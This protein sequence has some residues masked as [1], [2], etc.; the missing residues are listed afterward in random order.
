MY[1]KILV[2]IY[3]FIILYLNKRVAL[4]TFSQSF[5]KKFCKL[6]IIIVFVPGSMMLTEMF[7]Y[8]YDMS[9]MNQTHLS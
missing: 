1:T 3:N 8:T 2:L 7:L 6:F 5:L 9:I 4:A